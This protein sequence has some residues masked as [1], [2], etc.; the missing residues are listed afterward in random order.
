MLFLL[1]SM[2]SSTSLAATGQVTITSHESPLYISTS[3][4]VSGTYVVSVDD[5]PTGFAPPGDPLLAGCPSG[6]VA[7][8]SSFW[9]TSSW[10]GTYA[11]LHYKLDGIDKGSR[12]SVTWSNSHSNLGVALP[13]STYIDIGQLDPAVPHTASFYLEDVAGAQCYY[14]GYTPVMVRREQFAEDSLVFRIC[15]LKINSFT[16]NKTLID[17][18]KGERVTFAGNMTEPSGASIEW[19]VK[20]IDSSGATWHT[21]SGSGNSPLISWDGKDEFGTIV[22]DGLYTARLEA[23][24]AN[25]Q[26][27]KT[28]LAQVNVKSSCAVGTV[29]ISRDW[30]APQNVGAIPEITKAEIVTGMIALP[31]GSRAPHICV[32]QFVCLSHSHGSGCTSPSAPQDA[33]YLQNEDV[34][35]EMFRM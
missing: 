24:T 32:R 15:Y 6:Q 21:F 30:I 9:D 22:P 26:C 34:R 1:S 19:T 25:G 29:H 18:S 23:Q 20:I 13:F 10:T 16:S 11:T 4:T 7:L 28:A 17:P 3:F 31:V 8:S 12:G 35:E 14:L 27:L 2:I 5:T 33:A